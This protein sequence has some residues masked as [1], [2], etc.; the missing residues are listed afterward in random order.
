MI[1]LP[2]FSPTVKTAVL[3]TSVLITGYTIGYTTVYTI[4]LVL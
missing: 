2:Y 3:K 4:G 1:H